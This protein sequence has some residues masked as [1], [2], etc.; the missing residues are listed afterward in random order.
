MHVDT[1]KSPMLLLHGAQD[2]RIPVRQAEAFAEAL[3]AKRI[4]VR[5]KIFPHARHRIPVE[6]QDREILPFLEE[7][8]R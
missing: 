3:Q 1:I 5:V 4:A 8:L 2:E 6:E 7:S